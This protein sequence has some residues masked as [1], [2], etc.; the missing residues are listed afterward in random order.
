MLIRHVLHLV[1]D[2][3]LVILHEGRYYSL[4]CRFICLSDN[5]IFALKTSVLSLGRYVRRRLKILEGTHVLLVHRCGRSCHA[6]VLFCGIVTIESHLNQLRVRLI[7]ATQSWHDLC[8]MVRILHKCLEALILKLL[9]E[10]TRMNE[11]CRL[12]EFVVVA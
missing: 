7:H 9:G 1:E 2:A 3:V 8:G 4:L 6:I 10:L 5:D 11:L 12:A